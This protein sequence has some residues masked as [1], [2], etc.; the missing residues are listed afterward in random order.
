VRVT[1]AMADQDPA[2][3]EE[4]LAGIIV[5]DAGLQALLAGLA[6]VKTG[7]TDP[8]DVPISADAGFLFSTSTRQARPTTKLKLS[9]FRLARPWQGTRIPRRKAPAR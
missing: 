6:G 8:D 3:L 9:Q 1:G 4:L 5:D 2:K 7:R